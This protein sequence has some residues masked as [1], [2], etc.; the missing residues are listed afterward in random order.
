MS[1][2]NA[3]LVGA[4]AGAAATSLAAL[5]SGW[6][7]RWQVRRQVA[8]Q[9]D[10]MLWQGRRDAYSNFL[11]VFYRNREELSSL[12]HDLKDHQGTGP[13]RDVTEF[14]SARAQVYAL[15]HASAVVTVHGP[16]QVA[17]AAGRALRETEAF[18]SAL[19]TL[20]H[21]FDAATPD[22][23]VT[24]GALRGC[25]KQRVDVL[26]ALDGF[27]AS[28]RSALSVRT[29]AGSEALGPAP[30]SP[31]EQS[32]LDWL[33]LQA[34]EILNLNPADVD[35]RLGLWDLGFDSLMMVALASRMRDRSD[36]GLA[37]LLDLGQASVYELAVAVVARRELVR[38]D[39]SAS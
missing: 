11:A 9:F 8:A 15:Q 37:D 39:S 35:P 38:A 2:L 31:A 14:E 5:I 4:L 13:L 33:I 30:T 20:R 34:A 18:F 12:W 6:S 32:E 3:A 21:A 26:R 24:A 10:Q 36:I 17:A 25:G 28:A 22:H 7:A 1:Q 23:P 16:E 27:S 29:G 19:L